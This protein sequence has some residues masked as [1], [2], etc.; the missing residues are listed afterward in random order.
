MNP[1]DRLVLFF[2]P[3]AG[4]RRVAAR[5]Q[6]D[7]LMHYDGASRGTRTAGWKAP[8]TAADAAAFGTRGLLRQRSREMVRNRALAARARDVV[9]TNVIGQG[10]VPSVRAASDNVTGAVRGLEGGGLF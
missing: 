10:I 4:R 7:V 6:A 5:K 8:G 2:A 9:V 3:E 1:I